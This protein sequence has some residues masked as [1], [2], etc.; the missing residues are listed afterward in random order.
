MFKGLLLAMLASV[1]MMGH[2]KAFAHCM[3]P[4][5]KRLAGVIMPTCLT[6]WLLVRIMGIHYV[7]GNMRIVILC[8]LRRTIVEEGLA[9]RTVLSPTHLT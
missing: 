7:G 8:S 9:Q 6:Y 3:A 5:H 4:N 1:L 2:V